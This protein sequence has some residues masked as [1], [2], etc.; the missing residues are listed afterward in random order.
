MK[1]IILALLSTI[2]SITQASLELKPDTKK[3]TYKLSV[4]AIFKNEAAFLDEWITYHRMVGVEHFYLYNDNSTDN[5][6]EVLKPY[7]DQGIIDVTLW[8]TNGD[9]I[10]YQGYAYKDIIKRT[11]GITEWLAL[12]DLDEFILPTQEST[13]TECLDKYFKEAS[14]IYVNWY[15]FG[16]NNVSLKSGDLVLPL[17]TRCSLPDHSLNGIGKSIIKPHLVDEKSL[18]HPHHVPL[19]DNSVYYNGDG[20]SIP[21]SKERTEVV[22]KG[23]QHTKC[24]R[25]N[26]YSM[27]GEDKFQLKRAE[28]KNYILMDEH[29][30]AFNQCSNTDILTFIKKH[31]PEQYN[32]MWGKAQNKSFVMAAGHCGQLGNQF[33]QIAAACALA[34]DNAAEPYFPDWDFDRPLNNH[35]FSRINK[36]KPETTVAF[37]WR[38]PASSYTKIPYQDNMKIA[39]YFQS[40]KYFSHHRNRLLALFAPC[41]DD[42]AYMK[43]KYTWLFDSPHTVGV[44][45]RY[46]KWEFSKDDQSYPQYGKDYLDKAMR[47]FPEKSIFVVSSN[48]IQF[49]RENMPSWAKNVVFL[50]DEEPP[51]YIDLYLLSF[52]KH[53][54]ITNSSFGWWAAWLNQ[55][56]DKKVVRPAYWTAYAKY[57]PD[58][59][60]EEWIKID[61]LYD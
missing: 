23:N 46:Y 58:T 34:W 55:N 12:I 22:I 30:E 54:I 60:P 59:T 3:Y 38:D 37:E 20:V 18:W 25:I 4:G 6:Q 47:L 50:E 32:N 8:P 36:K 29:H 42:L 41:E 56:P 48:N 2:V 7:M 11:K 19:L 31:H 13:V 43:K 53:N 15:N 61:A 16:T 5:W 39:G 33:F 45:L 21:Y 40:E 14:A 1:K 35:V 24:M 49:A 28:R 51:Y 57:S 17:L 44:Q 10:S 26:H 52:C 27:R 9:L